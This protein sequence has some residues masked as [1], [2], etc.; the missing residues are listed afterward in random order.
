[1]FFLFLFL[2]FLVQV[3]YIFVHQLK[4]VELTAKPS[5]SVT[6]NCTATCSSPRSPVYEWRK[7]G[8]VWGGSDSFLTVAY[9]SATDT[10]N[11][12]HCARMDQSAREV[13]CSSTFECTASLPG[14]EVEDVTKANV[15]VV[16]SKQDCHIYCTYRLPI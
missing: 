13:D 4:D 5:A 16:L 14:M 11:T 10:H 12:Y 2:F 7:N 3:P 8:K 6:L 1:M 15:S 9:L